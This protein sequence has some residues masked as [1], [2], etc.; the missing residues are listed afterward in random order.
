MVWVCSIL[1]QGEELFTELAEAAARAVVEEV[2]GLVDRGGRVV[3]AV[4]GDYFARLVE[5]PFLAGWAERGPVL[6]GALGDRDLQ[7]VVVEPAALAGVAVD[8]ATVDAVLE[9]AAG[10]PQPLP[11]LSVAL[12]RAWE[13]RVD[14]RIDL[15]AYRSGGGVAGAIEAAAERCYGGMSD[16]QQRAT[17][18]LLVRLAHRNRRGWTGRALPLPSDAPTRQMVDILAASR[19][20]T[21][22]DHSVTPAHEA[23]LE[24]WPRLREWLDENAAAAELLGHLAAATD[25]WRAAGSPTTELYR[26]AR[27]QSVLDWRADHP[28]DLTADEAAF[29][30]ASERSAQAELSEARARADRERRGRR[31]LRRVAI[32][33]VAT[34]VAAV[35]ATTVAVSAPIGGRP[36]RRGCTPIGARGR[37]RAAGRGVGGRAGHRVRRPARGGRLPAAGFRRHPRSA[38][39]GPAAQSIGRLPGLLPNAH[40]RWSPRRAGTASTCTRSLR[41]SR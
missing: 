35:A 3:L 37:R 12:V 20:V 9:E 17:R 27:L 28:D 11:L 13:R 15:A 1:D 21:V 38:A 4:R 7:R 34:L 18:R 19:L 32:A 39:V 5:H 40:S 26:G 24:H 31:R 23:L 6:V 22:S 8:A 14:D 16:E 29:V 36:L 10:Q 30:D 33:L 25:A 41:P 2:R